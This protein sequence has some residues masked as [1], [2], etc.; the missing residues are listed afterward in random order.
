[1]LNSL[2]TEPDHLFMSRCLSWLHTWT[3]KRLF[4]KETGKVV[5]HGCTLHSSSNYQLPS[6]DA[7]S[8]WHTLAFWLIHVLYCLVFFMLASKVSFHLSPVIDMESHVN[9]SAVYYLTDVIS[10]DSV[11]LR[12]PRV[13]LCYT[14]L[15]KRLER[16]CLLTKPQ[17]VGVHARHCC[18]SVRYLRKRGMTGH[19]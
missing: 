5:T 11:V 2:E 3:V 1:M 10:H 9:R 4:S 17:L 16:E 13:S 14:G 18:C 7:I 15:V 19:M 8:C 12:T 6:D